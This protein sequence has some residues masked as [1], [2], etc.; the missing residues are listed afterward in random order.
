MLV[1][2]NPARVR[3]LN[4][5]GLKRKGLSSTDIHE[6]KEAFRLLYKSKFSFTEA[7]ENLH[8]LGDGKY[9]RHL[10][11][12]LKQSLASDKRRGAISGI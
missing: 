3:S 4:F 9:I 10:Q 8:S 5:V 12:F 7:V 6:L 1:E 11:S 2:G